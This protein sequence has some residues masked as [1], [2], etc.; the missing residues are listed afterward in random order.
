MNV[1][2][3]R[4]KVAPKSDGTTELLRSGGGMVVA[5]ILA[6]ILLET[7]LGGMTHIGART[8]AGWFALIVTLMCLPFGALL[9]ALG[10][11]KWLRNRSLQAHHEPQGGPRQNP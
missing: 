3:S 8:N 6:G 5:G 9:L 1:M 2:E 11:A 4:S 7:V 10:V